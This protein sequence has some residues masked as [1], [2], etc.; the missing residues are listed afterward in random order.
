MNE[1]EIADKYKRSR[2]PPASISYSVWLYCR[3]AL[4]IAMWGKLL[5]ERGV[6]LTD[7]S[8][9]RWCHKFGQ[10]YAKALHRRRPRLGDKWHLDEAFNGLVARARLAGMGTDGQGNRIPFGS[11]GTDFGYMQGTYLAADGA[12]QTSTFSHL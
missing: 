1:Q 4:S 8:V 9:R 12:R 11:P 7:E 5:A 2:F 10:G 6:T 3:F